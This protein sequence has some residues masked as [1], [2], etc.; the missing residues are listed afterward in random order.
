MFRLRHPPPVV[1]RYWKE[2]TRRAETISIP[3][4]VAE[5]EPALL[6][7]S[8]FHSSCERLRNKKK[9]IPASDPVQSA[10]SSQNQLGLVY[11]RQ[12]HLHEN[13]EPKAPNKPLEHAAEILIHQICDLAF[14]DI[15]HNLYFGGS[16]FLKC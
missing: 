3:V 9:R 16:F 4:H 12:S 8:H 7:S 15:D 6:S 14:P 1:T 10:V 2:R 13:T 11:R 5:R